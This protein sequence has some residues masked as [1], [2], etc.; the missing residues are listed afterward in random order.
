LGEEME[1]KKKKRPTANKPNNQYLHASH[2]QKQWH[3]QQHGGMVFFYVWRRRM[4]SVSA[5]LVL[6]SAPHATQPLVLFYFIFIY[7]QIPNCLGLTWQQR[8]NHCEK[9]LKPHDT[10]F[11]IYAFKRILVVSLCFFIFYIW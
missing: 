1:K 6:E 10:S 4:K 9:T 3:F 2:H 8:K 5:S 7:D 11:K